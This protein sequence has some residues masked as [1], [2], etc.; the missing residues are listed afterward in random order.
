MEFKLD[1]PAFCEITENKLTS[2]IYLINFIYLLQEFISQ[3]SSPKHLV[4]LLQSSEETGLTGV[5][6]PFTDQ[7][8]VKVGAVMDSDGHAARR[9]M[10]G[11]NTLPGVKGKNIFQLMWMALQ[12]RVLVNHKPFN[13]IT[14]K[15]IAD[16]FVYCRGGFT[17]NRT[18]SRL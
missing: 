6:D 14:L 2:G 7:K 18:L 4:G 5:I 10:F 12:D 17:F 9:E 3:F 8:A 11:T 15:Y 1:Y 13:L 16:S